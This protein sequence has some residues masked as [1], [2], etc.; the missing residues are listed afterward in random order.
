MEIIAPEQGF[1]YLKGKTVLAIGAH[2]DDLS[3]F[4]GGAIC[5]LAHSGAIVH[6]LR[7]TDDYAD[8]FEIP[9]DET[10][11]VNLDQFQKSMKILGVSKV[12]NLDYAT[13]QLSSIK[14]VDLREKIIFK[15]RELKP[16]AV[17]S[18]D[19]Y[20]AFGEDNQDHLMVAKAVDESY[21]TSIFDKHHPEHFSLGVAPH[22]VTERWYFG[23]ELT[24]TTSAID[25][26]QFLGQKIAA[27]NA[28]E[29]MMDNIFYQLKILE[30]DSGQKLLIEDRN[31][32][33][34]LM[35]ENMAKSAGEKY[36]LTCAE[37]YRIVRFNGMEAAFEPM[38]GA[39]TWKS[40]DWNGEE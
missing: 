35:I 2:A 8:S 6:A 28:H 17:I 21:W 20:S 30:R 13:D 5:A 14:L 7:V 4:A 27:V 37:N 15:F 25:I 18:F 19:P 9:S 12:H 1:S 32:L 26:S 36:G 10:K 3:I 29:I 34:Q 16:Y 22:A 38:A 24:R 11:R 31:T 39:R 23:R 33:V 40:P